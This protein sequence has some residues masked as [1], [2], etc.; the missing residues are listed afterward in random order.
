MI[1]PKPMLA[2]LARL[3]AS[4]W[5]AM[6]HE[7]FHGLVQIQTANTIY[8]FIDGVFASS[9]Q[10]PSHDFEHP[11]TFHGLRLI[12]FFAYENGFWSLSPRWCHGCLAVFWRPGA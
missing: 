5:N 9:A 6:A 10:K 11:D 12:G 4:T 3:S 7:A 2:K 1:L 8:R